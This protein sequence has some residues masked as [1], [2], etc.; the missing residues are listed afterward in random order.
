MPGISNAEEFMKRSKEGLSK[1]RNDWSRRR[2]IAP[3]TFDVLAGSP[4]PFAS[5]DKEFK[6]RGFNV[7]GLGN[8]CIV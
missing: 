4:V 2:T 1:V 8:E 5:S 7:Q 3:K 6:N